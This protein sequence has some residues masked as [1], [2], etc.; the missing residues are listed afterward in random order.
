MARRLTLAGCLLFL[1]LLLGASIPA[2]SEA[3]RARES[4]VRVTTKSP[5]VVESL[6]RRGVEILAF[7]EGRYLDVLADEGQIEFLRSLGVPLSI[8]NL[9]SMRSPVQD[10]DA[11]LGL[12]HTYTEM[13]S[14]VA[15]WASLYPNILEL[16]VLGPS[17]EGRSLYCLKISDNVTID[18]DEPEVLYMGNHHARELMSVEIPLLFAKYLLENYGIDPEVTDLVNGRE[19]YVVPMVNPDGHVYVE[20]NHSGSPNYWWRKNRRLNPDLT[21][22]GVDLNRNYGYEWGHDNIGS[23]PV[24]SGITYRGTAPFSEPETQAIRDLVEAREFATAFSYHSYGQLLLFPW[25]YERLNT[26][27]HDVFAALGEALTETNGYLPGNQASGAIG[28]LVNGGSDDWFYGEQTTK[29]KIFSFTAEV[30]TSS[31]GGFG[32]PDSLIGPTFDLLLPMNL[33]LAEVSDNPY[34]YVGPYAPAMSPIED[35]YYPIHTV[36]WSGNDPDDPNP[37]VSYEVQAFRD[38]STTY[39]RAESSSTLWEFDGFAPSGARYHEGAGSYYSGTGN[40]VDQTLAMTVPYPLSAVTDTFTC[41]LWYDIEPDF[42]YAYVEASTNDGVTWNTVQGN[43]TTENNPN[44]LNLGH[45]I[46]GSS[47][48]WVQAEFNLHNFVVPD[49]LLR[50]RYRTDAAW[51][52]EGIYVDLIDPV[53]TAADIDIVG[54]GSTEP[55]LVVAPTQAGT[56]TYRAR[57]LDA[58]DDRSRW[59]NT[60]SILI[61]DVTGTGDVPAFASRLGPN[62]PNPFNPVTVIPYSVGGPPGAGGPVEV[63]LVVYSVRGERVR[64]LVEGPRPPG[65]YRAIWDGRNDGGRAVGSGI[66]LVRYRVGREVVATRKAVLLK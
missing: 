25:S 65:R 30:N 60:A 50:F 13:E 26:P 52:Y 43:V 36:S 28:Y 54:T 56:Y 47:G 57:A 58:Q 64:T 42:D 37:V 1:L 63:S 22:Y 18:E 44:E 51:Y 4:F 29:E 32:P 59:S 2:S 61:D 24:Q 17:I 31:Q 39:D 12:Y 27:D 20:N 7:S 16:S 46:T 33:L 6:I 62:H 3:A 5:A 41:W 10:L 38:I 15:D 35:P 8:Q 53:A 49:L 48:G 23:T 21:S 34:V 19:I 9:E 11:D 66:Y 14:T 55:S 40:S 45:G